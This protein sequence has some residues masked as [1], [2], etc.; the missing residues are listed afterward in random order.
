MRSWLLKNTIFA[1]M[2]LFIMVIISM[3]AHAK[4]F[5]TIQTTVNTDNW[6][7]DAAVVKDTIGVTGAPMEAKRVESSILESL[8]SGSDSI[9]KMGSIITGFGTTERKLTTARS[10]K[11]VLTFPAINKGFLIFGRSPGATDADQTRA[12]AVRDALV[13]DLKQAI[14]L[15]WPDRSGIQDLT[16]FEGKMAALLTAAANGG[17]VGAVTFSGTSASE[18]SAA[19]LR[20][21]DETAES[22]DYVKAVTTDGDVYYLLFRIPKGYVPIAG[23]SLPR[24][25]P[26]MTSADD[27]AF[28]NWDML[29]VEAFNNFL[30]EGDN[31]VNSMN[32]YASAPTQMENVLVKLF[33]SLLTGIK[34]ALGLWKIDDLIYNTGLRGSSSYVHGVFPTSWEPVIWMFFVLTEL[35]AVLSLLYSIINNVLRRAL[36]T[37]NYMGRLYAWE[38]VKDIMVVALTLALL[39][40]V[41]QILLSLSYNLTG[42]L[43][44]SLQGETIVSLRNAASAGSGTLAGIV[45]QILFFGIDV[46][47]NFFYLLRS[48]TVAVLIVI[49][50][51]CVVSATFD[52]KRKS[53]LTS[54]SK[55]LLANIFIQP[56][57]A[58]IFSI[59]LL[60]PVGTHAFDNIM[61]FYATIPFTSAI[62][63]LFFG[64]A[65]SWGEQ[66]AGRAKNFATGVASG[67]AGGALAAA[68]GAA[69]Q[70]LS[71]GLGAKNGGSVPGGES[72]GQA[73]VSRSQA[74]EGGLSGTEGHI[75]TD[76]LT[77]ANDQRRRSRPEGEAVSSGQN[78]MDG[79]VVSGN[80]LQQR[81]S[82]PMSQQLAESLNDAIRRDSAV[83]A[84][85]E[86]AV[87]PVGSTRPRKNGVVLRKAAMIGGG[88][89]LGAIGGGISAA[90]GWSVG[91]ELQRGGK[92][93]CGYGVDSVAPA[94]GDNT[95]AEEQ[96]QQ[97]GGSDDFSQLFS[98]EHKGPAEMESNPLYQNGESAYDASRDMTDSVLDAQGQQEAGIANL[99]DQKERMQFDV[100][101]D[102]PY[103]QE[104]K[105]YAQVLDALPEAERQAVVSQTGIGV[106][107]VMKSGNTTGKY[108]V[109]IDKDAFEQATGNSIGVAGKSIRASGKGRQPASIVPSFSVMQSVSTTVEPGSPEYERLSHQ[110]AEPPQKVRN[111]FESLTESKDGALIQ[112]RVQSATVTP[113]QAVKI[114][115]AQARGDNLVRTGGQTIAYGNVA[116]VTLENRQSIEETG[117]PAQNIIVP[118]TM[119]PITGPNH[120]TN[121]ERRRE[122]SPAPSTTPTSGRAAT[123]QEQIAPREELE[124]PDTAEIGYEDDAREL[125]EDVEKSTSK[126]DW[127]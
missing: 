101:A 18:L 45:V 126:F 114:L 91:R 77:D 3:P 37:M 111:G 29:T 93:L 7:I 105:A 112:E 14:E 70:T 2:T 31:A 124:L 80:I 17:T 110:V 68:G 55:E 95:E 89:A 34:S 90:T 62:R 86:A 59:I 92:M 99:I 48:L 94:D 58:L 75:Q 16:E 88:I 13:Y 69:V 43:E 127:E 42:V 28:V 78:K 87:P 46:Y 82:N 20:L 64:G 5:F 120:D 4:D 1:I 11:L 74:G 98:E 26:Q 25:L 85:G 24:N 125:A 119:T 107:P 103:G 44:S 108:R 32:V 22:S 102:T 113:K 115:N 10:D 104:I 54:W 49:A 50:P 38:Q 81:A 79:N 66:A 8:A 36:S 65:G 40:V 116:P 118:G 123:G 96:E 117:R 122:E 97:P 39:P 53:M 35:F 6:T 19:G 51:I 15:A 100:E 60:F 23:R 9:G 106:S 61:L 30:L 33:S 47:Y 56:I 57:H 76:F 12:E 84:Q 52:N 41:L 27:A 67:V 71:G 63:G 73:N 83:Q 109:N 121:T 21:Y 72:Q